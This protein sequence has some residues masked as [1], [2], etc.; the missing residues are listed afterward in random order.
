[1][2]KKLLILLAIAFGTVLAGGILIFALLI[3]PV[4]PKDPVLE[5]LPEY[6]SRDFYTSGGFQDFTDYARYTFGEKTLDLE[7]HPLL[8]PVTWEDIP[9]IQTY[10]DDF[11]ESAAACHDFPGEAYD[12]ERDW[13]TEEDYFCITNRYEEPEK[14]FWSYNIYYFRQKD[15]TLYYFHNNI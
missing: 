2:M 4:L 12:F 5:S 11:E 10:L 3:Q 8:R 6:E 7:N 9:Q 1:M 13:L 15:Q 14:R